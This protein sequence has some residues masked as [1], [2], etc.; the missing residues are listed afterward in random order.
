MSAMR[1]FVPVSASFLLS[2]CGLFIPEIQENHFAPGDGQLMVQAIVQS[3]RCEM[4]DALKD[5]WKADHENAKKYH[6]KPVT[7]FLTTWGAQMTLTLTI[8]EKSSLAPTVSWMPPSPASAVF[9]LGGGVGAAADATRTDKLSFYYL[10]PTL[11]SQPYCTTGVQQGN[12]NSLLVQSN[13]K[14]EEWIVDYLGTLGTR[15]GQAPTLNTGALKDTV[16]SHDIKF[17]ITTSGNVTPSWKLKRVT[18]NPTGTF[19]STSRDRTHDLIITMGPGDKTGF[20]G[21]AA[22]TADSALQIGE[23][24]AQSLK[25]TLVTP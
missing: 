21:Y 20:T 13:L 23:A 19:F 15:E 8:D 9:T 22:I 18:Y 17:D 24:V 1:W 2:G 10:I 14:L 11:L 6:Q 16:L 7:E 5:V 12:E 4:I 25:G 3:V